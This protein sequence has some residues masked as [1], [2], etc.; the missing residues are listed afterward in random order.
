MFYYVE[1]AF[2]DNFQAYSVYEDAGA[3]LL[4]DEKLDFIV[5]LFQPTARCP[6]K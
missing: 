6:V 2:L 1:V 4:G 5:P 3:S